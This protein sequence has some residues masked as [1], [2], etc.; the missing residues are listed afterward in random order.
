MANTAENVRV[1]V[2]GSINYG[3]VGTTLPTDATTAINAAFDEVGY[4]NEDGITQSINEDRT[5]IKAWQ[6]ADVV[7]KIRTSHDV[8]YAFTML[9]TNLTT[10]EIYYG[11]GSVSGTLDNGV[12]EVRGDLSTRGPWV[13]HVIDGDELIRIVLPDG[14][15][16]ERGDT[17]YVNANAIQYPVTITAYPDNTGV[18]A[19]LYLAEEGS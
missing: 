14:E 1:A 16:T 15:V 5:E 13:L 9:E 8:T 19:Y 11:D 7:R 17:Q 6:N 18:K 12:V 4:A 2:T 3:P 10:L